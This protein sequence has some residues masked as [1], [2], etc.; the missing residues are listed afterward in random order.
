MTVTARA[1]DGSE[2]TFEAT[3]GSTRPNEVTY[4]INS[5]ILQTVLRKLKG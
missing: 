3:V 2:K 5:G 4:F 1:D